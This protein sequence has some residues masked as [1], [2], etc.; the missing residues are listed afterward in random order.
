M[1]LFY[2]IFIIAVFTLFFLNVGESFALEHNEHIPIKKQLEHGTSPQDL[3]CQKNFLLIFKNNNGIPACVKTESFIELIQRGWGVEKSSIIFDEL[4]QTNYEDIK[5]ISTE[6][7]SDMT[8]Y[9]LEVT[10]SDIPPT[11]IQ[12]IQHTNHNSK[13]TIIFSTGGGGATPYNELPTREKTLTTLLNEGFEIYEIVWAKP[14]GW[15]VNDGVGFKD[16]L[17]GYSSAVNWIAGTIA[18]NPTLMCAQ[19]NSGGGLQIA[20]GLSVYGLEDLFDMVILTGGPPIS[21]LDSNCFESDD[22]EQSRYFFSEDNGGREKTDII[23]GWK[24]DG[25][26]CQKQISNSEIITALQKTSLISETEYRDYN[27]P[28]TKVNFVNSYDDPTD[29]HEHG[30]FYYEQIETEKAWYD[31]DEMIHVVDGSTQGSEKIL[32]LFRHECKDNQ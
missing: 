21:K 20:Y 26:Y 18:D 2:S 29:S 14:G 16:A 25:K 6:K 32:D 23:M 27:F 1:R 5:L 11:K 22:P 13:G 28:F 8:C 12:V 15:F 17:C 7:C 24:R 9:N 19:G 3:I 10:C 4:P 31:I 30:K